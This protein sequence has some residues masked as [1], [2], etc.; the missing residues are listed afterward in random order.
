MNAKLTWR[1]GSPFYS[2]NGTEYIPVSY[3]TCLPNTNTLKNFNDKGFELHYI[4]PSGILSSIKAP[5]SSCGEVWEGEGNYNWERLRVHVNTVLDACP[6]AKLALIVQLDTRDWYLK[7]NGDA[8]DSYSHLD[9]MCRDEKWRQSAARFLKD[10][11]QFMEEEYPERVYA[12]Y[13]FAGHTCEWYST[14]PEEGLVE[15]KQFLKNFRE[16][17]GDDQ[18]IPTHE[19]LMNTT[20]GVFRHP[21]NDQKALRFWEFYSEILADTISY[22]AGKV[23]EY[24]DGKLLVGVFY[25]YLMSFFHSYLRGHNSFHTVVSNPDVDLI[26]LRAHICLSEAWKVSMLLI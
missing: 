10:V 12:V 19:E 4:Y 13:L 24:T 11:I 16:W 6:N 21:L 8:W 25:G 5:Y 18:E 14:Y 15:S 17:F 20:Y 2:I 9:F 1:N 3:R 23:K 7:Q 22:F 26:F